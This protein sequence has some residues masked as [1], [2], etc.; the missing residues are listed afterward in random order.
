[1]R[2]GFVSPE[3]HPF[4]KTGG[5]ADVAD[6]LPEALA[7]LGVE[8]TVFVPLYR[9][10]RA[11]L[12]AQPASGELIAPA[13]RIG[14]GAAEE[15]LAYR[16]LPWRGHRVVLVVNDRFYDRA[17]PYLAPAG[18]DY[19]DSVARWTFFC[20]AVLEYY[21]IVEPPP[22]V[23]HL[24][25]WQS[26]LIGIYVKFPGGPPE[27]RGTPT[28][29]TIHN[30]AFQG[31]FPRERFLE[32]G[33]GWELFTPE[34]L[35]FYGQINLLKGGITSA[36]AVNA[37]S[38]TYAQEIQTSEHGRGLDGV[39]RAQRHKLC[40]ILNG[41][42]PAVWN[43]ATDPQLPAH[44]DARDVAGKAVCKAALQRRMGLPERSRALLLGVI[45]RFDVQKGMHLIVEAFPRL[46]DLDVQLVILGDGDRTVRQAVENLV[47]LHPGRAAA[48]V[49]FDEA[50]AHLI[51]G[52]A[53]A[54]LMP[55]AFEPCGLNQMYSQRYGTAPIVRETGGLKDTVVDAIPQRLAS[56]TAS[57]FTFRQFEAAELEEAV[58]R[59]WA[60]YTDDPAGWRSL[61]RVMMGLDHSWAR[62][63]PSY[64][65][66]YGR[67]SG[68]RPASP[69]G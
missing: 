38:P 14:I 2:I 11:W 53:D 52:G 25:D 24:N 22:A 30:L 19:P 39:L 37:V 29:L 56:G 15:P 5:L 23:L 4:L 68:A 8:A 54:F 20:R 48:R 31:V 28:L 55:S 3:A 64:V 33:L 41:I 42:D 18:T 16:T 7:Q 1:M 44:Y 50:L 63:A 45:S 12:D 65:E 59:A 35:E 62:R 36:D 66:L 13:R 69:P 47:R 34:T 17:H 60:L 43:P 32:T 57:G 49:G 9:Q 46:R 27:L 26:A 67:L 40:G 51:E 21:R 6:A 58:R 10:A 61:M